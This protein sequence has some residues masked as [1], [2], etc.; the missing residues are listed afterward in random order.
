VNDFQFS[1]SSNRIKISQAT[2]SAAQALNKVI[3]HFPDYGESGQNPP[4][5]ING[6]GLPTI[7][8]FAPWNNGEDLTLGDDYSKVIRRHTLKVGFLYSRNSKTRTTLPR[9]GRTLPGRLQR[10]QEFRRDSRNESRVL[11][12]SRNHLPTMVLRLDSAN[13]AVNWGEQDVIF[14]K[15][16][17]WETQNFI[18]TTT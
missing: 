16:G 13:Q 10:L 2:P 3:Q 6:G 1:Y 5:W 7:W 17:R 8:S 14:K 4:V 18:S 11:E 12:L 9:N 15:Q